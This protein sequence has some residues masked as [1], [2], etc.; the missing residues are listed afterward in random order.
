L[1][2]DKPLTHDESTYLAMIGSLI[3]KIANQTNNDAQEELLSSLVFPYLD[4]VFSHADNNHLP[5]ILEKQI[6]TIL[7]ETLLRGEILN[8][9]KSEHKY[10]S[11][12]IY[13]NSQLKIVS[14]AHR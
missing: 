8:K 4:Q 14:K 12:K 3:S 13:L 10:H 5:E 2:G 11:L 7:K 6:S 1:K 9:L